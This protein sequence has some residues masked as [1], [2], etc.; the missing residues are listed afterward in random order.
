MI[1]GRGRQFSAARG[2]PLAAAPP[3]INP[4][5]AVRLGLQAREEP[6]LCRLRTVPSLQGAAEGR[7]EASP[8]AASSLAQVPL[9]AAR[10]VGYPEHQQP[11]R[12]KGGSEARGGAEVGEPQRLRVGCGELTPN[13][14]EGLPA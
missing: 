4:A 5:S 6:L 3:G 8:R 11:R 9:W 10:T 2:R 7:S 1:P 13:G 14:V 12:G